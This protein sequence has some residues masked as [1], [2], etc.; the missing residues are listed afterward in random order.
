MGRSIFSQQL[1][2]L[3][4]EKGVTQ[5]EL[6]GVLGVSPQ[7]VSK[8]ENGS[9]PD[10][11]LLPRLADYFSVTID[12]LYGRGER[13][14]NVEQE[15]VTSLSEL[16]TQDYEKYQQQVAEKIMKYC[17]GMQLGSY[18]NSKWYYDP[19]DTCT[20]SDASC[21]FSDN[22]CTF[23]RLGPKW[24]YFM[25]CPRPEQGYGAYVENTAALSELFA[26]LGNEKNLK[27][28]LYFGTL[29][30]S[31]FVSGSQLK[32]EFSITQEELS[33]A[34]SFLLKFSHPFLSECSTVG[35]NERI[36]QLPSPR[37][38]PLLQLLLCA[39]E[40]LDMPQNWSL[41][42]QWTSK[43]LIRRE[44]LSWLKKEKRS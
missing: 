28:L 25:A 19:S 16:P 7:A 38:L 34:V 37:M 1:C 21:L 13:Q 24:R 30:A 20:S 6:A 35:D 9:Y 5:E 4:K 26:F 44:E 3:R 36:Y 32:K 17:W 8:W 40:L 11:D 31:E 15:I 29:S 27:I 42:M 10:G 14:Q 2:S 41:Q 18:S 23:M 39:A 22:I 33:E 43:P 12:Y